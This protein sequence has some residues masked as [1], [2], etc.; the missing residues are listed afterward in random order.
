MARPLSAHVV[1]TRVRF[2]RIGMGTMGLGGYFQRVA[3][4]DDEAIRALSLAI[5]LG[6]TLIDTAE[7]YGA[8]HTE[9]LVGRAVR[10]R[11]ADVCIATKFSPEHS[12]R[13]GVLAAADA[14]LRRLGI[15]TIDLYQTHWPNPAVPFEETLEAL[16]W[17]VDKGKV[18]AIGLSNPTLAQIRAT[19]ATFPPETFVA[20][21]QQ[22]SLADRVVEH[23]LLPHCE[24]H[25]LRFLAYSPLLEGGLLRDDPRHMA[26]ADVARRH[27]M[28]AAQMA[29]A[30]VARRPAVTP[31]P[32]A[33]FEAHLR[34]NAGAARLVLDASAVEAIE[35]LY[36][37]RLVEIMP[38]QIEIA[39]DDS[40]AVYKTLDEALA[41]PRS[42]VPSPSD[43]ANEIRAGEPIRPVK[44]RRAQEGKP[45]RLVEGRVRFWAWVIAY[46]GRRPIVALEV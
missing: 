44:V 7:G 30:W 14:S 22:Y 46:D 2:P 29:L 34:E 13:R 32:K 43:L 38:D 33:T 20:V 19:A 31:I 25:G 10:G 3:V 8:G 16:S 9:E 11:R 18:R 28:S 41:N 1:D 40:R 12:A 35:R 6:L 15:E 42:F 26:L 45:Y 4:A 39:D 37:L 24:S 27:G 5:D 21:Q 36:P 17:L 23:T